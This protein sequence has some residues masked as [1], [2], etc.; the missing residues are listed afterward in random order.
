[1]TLKSTHPADAVR[2]LKEAY[3]VLITCHRNPDGD[4]LGSELGL[5]EMAARFGVQ[6]VIVNR[7]RTPANLANLPGADRIQVADELPEDFP[8]AYDLVITVECPGLDRT[9]FEGLTRV[10]ILNIDHHP[11]NPAYGVVNFLDEASP[12]V[13]EMVWLMYVEAGLAPSADAATNLFVALSTD[14]GDF[15]YSNATGRAFRAAAEMVDAGAR[16]ARVANW[17][18]NHRSLASVRLLGEA[19]QTLKIMCGGKLA[20]ITADQDAFE[21][22]GAGPEDTEEIVNVPRS[23]SGVEA[24]AYFKQWEDGTVRVSLRSRGDVDVRAVAESFGGGGHVNAA[25]CA[26]QGE[27]SQVENDVSSAMAAALGGGL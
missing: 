27:L 3:R 9:G 10:P 16:P 24:V 7:D 13:G 1:V 11:A 17:V 23:I 26:V 19:L 15:R 14:T 2:R 8:A 18:H 25:G 12:A 4:A 20:V 21:R 6:A 5:A 22:A